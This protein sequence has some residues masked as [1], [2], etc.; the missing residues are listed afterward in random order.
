MTEKTLAQQVCK[1]L[2]PHCDE[3]T[4]PLSYVEELAGDWLPG[5]LHK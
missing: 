3:E 1:I 5:I 2:L 4:E